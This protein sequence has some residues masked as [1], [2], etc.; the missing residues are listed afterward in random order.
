MIVI[1]PIRVV[2]VHCEVETHSLVQTYDSDNLHPS[3]I[4]HHTGAKHL[5]QLMSLV[6]SPHQLL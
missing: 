6:F 4:V 3:S 1:A 2:F 5:L